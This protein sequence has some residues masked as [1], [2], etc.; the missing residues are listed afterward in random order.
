MKE[1]RQG[2]GRGGRMEDR[3]MSKRNE[4]EGQASIKLALQMQRNCSDPFLA[5]FG[6]FLE[7]FHPPTHSPLH[8]L[9]N[10]SLT[11]HSSQTR[12]YL[13]L[14]S[15][16]VGA[17]LEQKYAQTMALQDSAGDGIYSSAFN[18]HCPQSQKLTKLMAL[19]G[20]S[21]TAGYQRQLTISQ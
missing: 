20:R 9:A 3:S 8:C 7:P 2:G 1:R 19:M 11:E 17:E 13:H 5:W 15:L 16:G 6:C 12:Y 14:S 21:K 10:V 18:C 4:P